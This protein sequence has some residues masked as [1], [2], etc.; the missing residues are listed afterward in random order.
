MMSL[1]SLRKQLFKG[2]I[3]INSLKN[4][5]LRVFIASFKM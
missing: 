2:R 5:T 4:V 1:F 3:P